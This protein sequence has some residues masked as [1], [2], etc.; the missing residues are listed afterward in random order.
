MGMAGNRIDGVLGVVVTFIS[1]SASR[2]FDSWLRAD[3]EKARSFDVI[4]GFL[5]SEG[6]EFLTGLLEGRKDLVY[7]VVFGHAK[8]EVLRRLHE[9]I[10]RGRLNGDR[11][12]LHPPRDGVEGAGRRGLES[13]CIP[14]KLI[15]KI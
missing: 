2:S 5:S 8:L 9:M 3:V 12:R 13:H 6:L 4:V 7:R 14:L 15:I 11:I 1:S 10:R